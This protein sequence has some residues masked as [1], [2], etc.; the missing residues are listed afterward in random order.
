MHHPF[1][2]HHLALC[3]VCCLTIAGHHVVSLC[4]LRCHACC[5]VH[6]VVYCA[7]EAAQNPNKMKQENGCCSHQS[8]V[9]LQWVR[10]D[11]VCVCGFF[12]VVFFVDKFLILLLCIA[13]FLSSLILQSYYCPF[14]DRLSF[15]CLTEGCDVGATTRGHYDASTSRSNGDV[16][17]SGGAWIWVKGEK[18]EVG[19]MVATQDN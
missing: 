3:V 7:W 11:D 18:N 6:V 5:E 10:H 8:T 17:W 4:I 1:S 16:L 19:E 15:C 14:M 2:G 9:A 12:F 13:F